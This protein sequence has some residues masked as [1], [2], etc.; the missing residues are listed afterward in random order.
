MGNRTIKSRLIEIYGPTCFLGDIPTKKNVLTYHHIKPVREGRITT[1]ENGA[2]LTEKMH[3]LFNRIERIDLETA[4]YINEYF[5][6]YKET[7]D[8]YER[9]LMHDFVINYYYDYARDNQPEIEIFKKKILTRISYD[10]I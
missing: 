3:W 6:Y 2:L 8:Q 9:Y 7:Q 10:I 4:R 5:K 1:I